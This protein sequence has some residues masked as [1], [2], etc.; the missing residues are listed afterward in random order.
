M[1]APT[2]NFLHTEAICDVSFGKNRI[3][4]FQAPSNYTGD[5]Y[6]TLWA[7]PQRA[8]FTIRGESLAQKTIYAPTTWSQI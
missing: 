3:W 4:L 5:T 6:L 8:K 1:N 7:P 2:T